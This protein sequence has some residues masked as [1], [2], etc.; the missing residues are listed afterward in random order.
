MDCRRMVSP[1]L[2]PG[3]EVVPTLQL[4]DEALRQMRAFDLRQM[5]V[6]PMSPQQRDIL[7]EERFVPG[8][9]GAPDVRILVYRAPGSNPVALPAFVHI[10]GGGYI[11]GA[12]E[13]NE[14]FSRSIA[15]EQRCIV[16]SVDYRLAPETRYPGSLEDCYAAL[17]WV[18]HNAYEL[19]V[20]TT[21]IAI[22]GESAGGGHAAALTIL[23][24][25]RG[26]VPVCF[27]LLDS[28]MLDDRTG[29]ISEPH[30]FAGKFVWTPESNRF[31][32]R[33]LL[34]VE[35]GGPAVPV[36]AVPARTLDFSGL[37]ATCI[38]IG[39]LDLFLEETLE[40]V[41]RLSRAGVPIEL[42]VTPG[43]YHG[44]QLAGETA[45]QVQQWLQLRSHAL[46]RAFMSMV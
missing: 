42:H 22:G 27:Q 31:G 19:N 16:V 14:S 10:H 1:E 17:L 28:P 6:P 15:L 21:R 46:R 9:A 39:A 41:R 8:P 44:Y 5:P 13:M 26:E 11:M 25:D 3:L 32:W 43:A 34:G 7:R 36:G 2:Q 23:A 29:T 18:Y 30:P 20:D 33:A 40:Y 38:T 4:S 37:P 45:P 35:P 24:R 12:P